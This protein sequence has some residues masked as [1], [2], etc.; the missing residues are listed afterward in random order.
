M[1]RVEY[2][3]IYKK[4]YFYFCTSCLLAAEAGENTIE[5]MAKWNDMIKIKSRA[6]KKVN[7]RKAKK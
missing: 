3:G 2:R 6:L 5:A 7:K 1:P 4:H